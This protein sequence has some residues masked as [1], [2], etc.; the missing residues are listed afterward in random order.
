MTILVSLAIL[1][2]APQDDSGLPTPPP[3]LPQQVVNGNGTRMDCTP[4]YTQCWPHFE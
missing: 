1:M 4:N 2:M 3:Q